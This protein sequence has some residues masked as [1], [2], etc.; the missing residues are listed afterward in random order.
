MMISTY[1]TSDPTPPRPL[2]ML[3]SKFCPRRTL[4][5]SRTF[6]C[7]P[8]LCF[9]RSGRWC[10]WDQLFAKEKKSGR[11]FLLK[12]TLFWSRGK[13]RK[14]NAALI[15]DASVPISHTTTDGI[16]ENAE[17]P[18]KRKK[19]KKNSSDAPSTL[20]PED[21]TGVPEAILEPV[22][23]RPRKVAAQDVTDEP[24]PPAPS[25]TSEIPGAQSGKPSDVSAPELAKKKS[26]KVVEK[27][28]ANKTIRRFLRPSMVS[29]PRT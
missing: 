19:V 3:L 28:V 21:T 9:C 5:R 23:I 1:S 29:L 24:V 27:D 26:K 10:Q 16:L 25:T 22:K 13:K 8:Y 15:E 17:L 14:S 18:K 4:K 20:P 6:C 11:G 2:Y 7:H 12:T